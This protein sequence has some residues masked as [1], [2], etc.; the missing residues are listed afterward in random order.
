MSNCQKL[1]EQA[2]HSAANF[3]FDDLCTL[4]E[5]YGWEFKRQKGSHKIYENKSLTPEQ[6][7]TMNFQNLNGNAKPYQVKQ[8]LA[9]IE[10]L[11]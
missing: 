1:Y 9:A 4:A 10:E 3:R 2:Q 5:C 11:P 8:L 6:G 7:R